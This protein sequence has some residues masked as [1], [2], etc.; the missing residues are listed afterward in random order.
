MSKAA[1]IANVS[2]EEMRVILSDRGIS[3][4]ISEEDLNDKVEKLKKLME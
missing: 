1:E 4:T 3:I 2:F